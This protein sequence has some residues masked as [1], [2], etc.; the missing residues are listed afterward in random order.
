M[1]LNYLRRLVKIFDDSTASELK[2][3]EEGTKIYLSKQSKSRE[4]AI[5]PPQQYFMPQ[6]QQQPL[7]TAFAQPAPVVS[8]KDVKENDATNQENE[9]LY[10]ITSPMVGTFY[11]APSPDSPS[12]V[13]IGSRVL[14]GMVLCI[15]EA[16]KL[17]NEIEC[18]VTGTVVEINNPNATPVEFGQPLFVIKL[19]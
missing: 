14:P 10:K 8:E 1:D 3:E 9:K 13:D 12:Y 16:M 17:M 11:R 5:F 6:L 19:D 2:I 15:I 7:V 18:D 4:S